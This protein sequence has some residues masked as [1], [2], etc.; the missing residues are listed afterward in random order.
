MEIGVEGLQISPHTGGRD[1]ELMECFR[2]LFTVTSIWCLQSDRCASQILGTVAHSNLDSA[3]L[4]NHPYSTTISE[5]V[6]PQSFRRAI[7]NNHLLGAGR[8]FSFKKK[9]V[10]LQSL[11]I[12]SVFM[13][14]AQVPID[15]HLNKWERSEKSQHCNAIG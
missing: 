11:N 5:Y 13:T 6:Y 3:L 4:S 14:V 10:D 15:N 9:K 8:N 7:A 12:W 1:M 2:Y